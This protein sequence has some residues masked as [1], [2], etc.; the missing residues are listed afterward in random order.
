MQKNDDKLMGSTPNHFQCSA[1]RRRKPWH[2]DVDPEA[3]RKGPI[4]RVTLTG[5]FTRL[6]KIRGTYRNCLYRIE[7]KCDDCGHVG[8][9]NHI[10]L[11]HKAVDEGLITPEP[12]D[13]KL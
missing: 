12:L 6:S 4:Q 7:Y 9:S 5:K 13:T 8:K 11:F 2:P 3:Y 10:Y 1:C